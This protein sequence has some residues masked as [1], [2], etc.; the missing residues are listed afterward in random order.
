MSIEFIHIHSI[1]SANAVNFH[2]VSD[3]TKKNFFELFEAG[4][5][6]SSAY[7]EYKNLLR[8][9]YGEQYVTIS[10]DR[11]I[12]PDYQW[13]YRQYGEY[14]QKMFG[15]INSPEAFEKAV[16]KVKEY[17]EKHNENLCVIEQISGETIV[18]VCD[19]LSS[20]HKLET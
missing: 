14:I 17:N 1:E 6:P 20:Y 11:A 8:A 9:K 2:I 5:A 3:D 12:M 15:K 10:A 4:H 7:H 16:N 13:V 19:K 18:A